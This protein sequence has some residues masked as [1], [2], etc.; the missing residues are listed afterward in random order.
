MTSAILDFVLNLW[1]QCR[2]WIL[3]LCRGTCKLWLWTIVL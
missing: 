2:Y 1:I 3:L